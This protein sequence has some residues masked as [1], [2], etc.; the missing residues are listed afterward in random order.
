[1]AGSCYCE[2]GSGPSGSA[3]RRA[4][5]RRSRQR[6]R[7][8]GELLLKRQLAV[9]LRIDRDVEERGVARFQIEPL[10][11]RLAE[12]GGQEDPAVALPHGL[13]F[14]LDDDA[15]C[16]ALAAKIAMGPDALHLGGALVV[17]LEGA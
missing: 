16:E 14:Q 12:A 6:S 1:M 5:I 17:A 3:E 11:L 10:G 13:Q 4:S 8:D 15:T 9:S 7:R 2:R